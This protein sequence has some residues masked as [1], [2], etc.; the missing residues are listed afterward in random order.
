VGGRGFKRYVRKLNS[1]HGSGTPIVAGIV[2]N[3]EIKD[4]F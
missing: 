1:E 4:T 3:T 2:I